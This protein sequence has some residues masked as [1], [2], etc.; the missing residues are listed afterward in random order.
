MDPTLMLVGL[1]V[2][3]ITHTCA[4]KFGKCQGWIEIFQEYI[5]YKKSVMAR[6]EGTTLYSVR[7]LGSGEV[8]LRAN[9]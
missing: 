7:D 2:L 1:V 5:Q 8:S 4:Y 3:S 9:H 6:K